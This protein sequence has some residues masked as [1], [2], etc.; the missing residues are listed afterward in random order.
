[1]NLILVIVAAIL[2]VLYGLKWLQSACLKTDGGLVVFLFFIV[3][4]IFITVYFYNFSFKIIRIR[5]QNYIFDLNIINRILAFQSV[6][7]K[8]YGVMSPFSI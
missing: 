6:S 3:T 4:D 2:F 7:L 1:M 5:L 8:R